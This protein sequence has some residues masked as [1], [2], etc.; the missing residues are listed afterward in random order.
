MNY[1][2]SGH[3]SFPFRYTWI[4]KAIRGLQ[5]NPHLFSDDDDDEAMV[6]LGIGK[7]MVRSM[8]FWVQ[9]T[10]MAESDERGGMKPSVLGKL[11]FNDAGLDPFLE[12]IQT[13]WLLHWNIATQ[14]E[15]PLFAWRFLLNDWQESEFAEQAV[16]KAF[17]REAQKLARKLSVVTLKQHFE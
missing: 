15:E 11:L 2:F 16:L 7:N 17:E 8:R 1:R 6:S 10:G 5:E 4:P 13:L 12:D 3:E 9:A 14:T